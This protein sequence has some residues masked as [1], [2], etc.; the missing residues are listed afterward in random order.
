MSDQY[1]AVV[2]ELV[3]CVDKLYQ[4][5]VFELEQKDEEIKTLTNELNEAN[6]I[7]WDICDKW[8]DTVNYE[9]AA[10]EVRKVLGRHSEYLKRFGI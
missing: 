6:Q 5:A 1:K 2:L 10:Y 7:L 3:N 8:K 9:Q 4:K